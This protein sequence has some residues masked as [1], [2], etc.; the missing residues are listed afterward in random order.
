MQEFFSTFL[1]SS[2]K[3]LLLIALLVTAVA[4]ASIMT[5]IYNSVS[6]RRRE[7]AVLRAL[8]ATRRRILSLICLEALLVGCLGGVLG[9][10]AGH[11]SAAQPARSY[12]N[13]VVGEGNQLVE[14]RARR[15]NG[16]ISSVSR[17][18]RWRRDWYRD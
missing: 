18:W 11:L 4:A 8:G 3:V 16:D 10:I 17:C 7:I 5:T 6:A 15:G 1:D 2:A 13:A 9:L 12:M 14:G